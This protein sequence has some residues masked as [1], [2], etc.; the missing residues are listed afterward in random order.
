M[1]DGFSVYKCAGLI[2]KEHWDKFLSQ[3][4]TLN[5]SYR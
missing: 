2:M 1:R 5:A 4:S 3:Q